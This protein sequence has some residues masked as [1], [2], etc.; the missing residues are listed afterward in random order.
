MLAFATRQMAAKVQKGPRIQEPFMEGRT[1]LLLSNVAVHC[2]EEYL[3]HWIE[4]RNYKVCSVHLIEDI[5]SG[6]SPSFA[7]VQL[8]DVTR[9]DEAARKLHG[10]S[11]LGCAVRVSHVVPLF[12]AVA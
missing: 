6:T 5:V 3:K 10:Q 4:A 11:L 9:L 12:F 1:R 8:I 7:Y 2:T